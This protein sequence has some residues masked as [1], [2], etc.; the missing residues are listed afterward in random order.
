MQSTLTGSWAWQLWL[1]LH[2]KPAL[3]TWHW[4]WCCR[5]RVDMVQS[6]TAVHRKNTKLCRSRS[7]MLIPFPVWLCSVKCLVSLTWPCPRTTLGRLWGAGEEK[8]QWAQSR[9]SSLGGLLTSFLFEL[10]KCT[11]YPLVL[12]D[13]I[14]SM[15]EQREG[16]FWWMSWN[17]K[18]EDPKPTG[19]TCE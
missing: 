14:K 1:A 10:G 13:F 2:W 12:Y 5:R 15:G 8:L 3:E 17:R 4:G 11:T 6:A 7:P 9:V 16:L 18:T 19:N